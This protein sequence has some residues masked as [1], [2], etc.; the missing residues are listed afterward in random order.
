[1]PG[2]EH[3]PAHNRAGFRAPVSRLLA[4]SYL[5]HL[6]RLSQPEAQRH[7]PLTVHAEYRK[8]V[9]SIGGRRSRMRESDLH[10]LASFVAFAIH[11]AALLCP[12]SLV[13]SIATIAAGLDHSRR[14]WQRGWRAVFNVLLVLQVLGPGFLMCSFALSLSGT[15]VLGWQADGWWRL[16]AG[17]AIAIVLTAVCG[18]L[19]L[20]RQI[21]T[22]RGAAASGQV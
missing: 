15:L 7:A 17:S 12:L 4:S 19:Y 18:L 2:L 20:R 5:R 3:P 6:A 21:L 22:V 9:G 13:L 1:M 14:A 16:A 10:P 8:E 11:R